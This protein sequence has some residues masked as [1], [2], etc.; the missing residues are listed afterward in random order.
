MTTKT[1]RLLY[2]GVIG[3]G[4]VSCLQM[5]MTINRNITLANSAQKTAQESLHRAEKNKKNRAVYEQ[6]ETADIRNT[7]DFKAIGQ[8]FLQDMFKQLSKQQINDPKSSVATDKVVSAFLGATFGGDVDEGRPVIK[9]VTDD[10]VY[11]KSADGSGVGFGTITYTQSGHKQHITLL[12][13]INQQKITEIQVGQVRD[14][15]GTGGK[16]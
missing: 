9:Y 1:R 5:G 3:L 8:T 13:Q 14:T 4:I 12:L 6:I 15:S 10:L 11:S 16:S 7:D 2:G